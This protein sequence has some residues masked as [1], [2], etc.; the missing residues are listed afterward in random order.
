MTCRFVNRISGLRESEFV[1]K[2]GGRDREVRFRDEEELLPARGSM[3]AEISAASE[4]AQAGGVT[5]MRPRARLRIG[6]KVG[7]DCLGE[8][9]MGERLPG[10]RGQPEGFRESIRGYRKG[11]H[12]S[13]S[14]EIEPPKESGMS[15]VLH[16]INHRRL[17][18]A[19]GAVA[20]AG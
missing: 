12:R 19:R 18:S 13:C 7:F 20:S 16:I 17:H 9:S 6:S 14:H 5:R 15:P 4:Q 2:H 11:S 10:R 8:I 3:K 1:G